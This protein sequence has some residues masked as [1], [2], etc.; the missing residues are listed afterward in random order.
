MP[1]IAHVDFPIQRL[2][3]EIIRYRDNFLSYRNSILKRGGDLS[4]LEAKYCL[5]FINITNTHIE[6]IKSK[7]L[8]NSFFNLNNKYHRKLKNSSTSESDHALSALEIFNSLYFAAATGNRIYKEKKALLDKGAA[9]SEF[10][11]LVNLFSAALANTRKR[12][13]SS[14]FRFWQDDNTLTALLFEK[15]FSTIHPAQLIYNRLNQNARQ[16]FAPILDLLIDENKKYCTVCGDADGSIIR[17]L[18]I[19]IAE[20]YVE[21]TNDDGINIMVHLLNEEADALYTIN[22]CKDGIWR[23]V[24][25]EFQSNSE[26]SQLL[27]KLKDCIKFSCP[28]GGKRKALEVIYLGDILHDRLSCNKEMT[29][30]YINEMHKVRIIFIFGNHDF[31]LHAEHNHKHVNTF[32]SYINSNSINLNSLNKQDDDNFKYC[33]Q[34]GRFCCKGITEKESK[35]ITPVFKNAY[36]SSELQILFTHNGFKISETKKNALETAFGPIICYTNGQ[37]DPNLFVSEMNAIDVNTWNIN[38]DE[39]RIK[40]L[41]DCRFRFDDINNAAKK[42]DIYSAH[43][44]EGQ[45]CL[46]RSHI[47]S[48]NPR[49]KIEGQTR[50][51]NFS[52]A[53]LYKYEP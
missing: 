29:A 1:Y 16:L 52:V 28:I 44:H 4:T 9:P 21:F 15:R 41:T 27:E 3:N 43:G 26:N 13:D 50:D 5:Y 7:N 49:K 45:F 48:M 30:Y 2:P 23:Y 17:L 39:K 24:F 46:T 20:N 42:A 11:F 47:A 19:A 12:I 35:K 33:Y 32:I 37:F 14:F 36:F 8:E 31:S 38:L 53:K 6:N 51:L 40:N 34:F 25:Y 22:H 10:D 18:F